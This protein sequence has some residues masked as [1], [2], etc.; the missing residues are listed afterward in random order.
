MRFLLYLLF[1]C[2]NREPR[3]KIK[4]L[5][6]RY[7]R[8]NFCQRNLVLSVPIFCR[9]SSRAS[10]ALLFETVVAEGPK[11]KNLRLIFAWSPREVVSLLLPRNS[12]SRDNKF[13]AL[14]WYRF[15]LILCEVSPAFTEHKSR[16]RSCFGGVVFLVTFSKPRFIS[17]LALI[18]N[19][20]AARV[21][22]RNCNVTSYLLNSA[23]V[24][25]IL[26][27]VSSCRLYYILK[28]MNN[29]DNYK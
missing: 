19:Y 1:F 25:V 2:V 13:F 27:Y 11:K 3:D 7:I 23:K 6:P 8:Y 9:K 17:H 16:W 29:F 21:R 12:A 5:F 15:R 28:I 20:F 18:N 26:V 10:S 24:Q 4:I 22:V 14:F